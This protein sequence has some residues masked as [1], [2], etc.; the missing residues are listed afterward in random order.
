MYGPKGVGA[1]YIRKRSGISIKPQM[2]GGGQESGIRPGTLPTHQLVGMGE[3]ARL[4]KQR[5]HK[6][7]ETVAALDRYLLDSLEDIELAT[8]NGNQ[9]HRVP[10]IVN[11]S[12]AYVENESL[13]MS[14]K[15]V[16]ISSGSACTSSRIEPSHVLQGLGIS[17][18]MANCSVRFSLGRQTTREE[19]DFVAMRVRKFIKLL[20]ELSPEWQSPN[21]GKQLQNNNKAKS[22][23]TGTRE[24]VV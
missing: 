15:D 7:A 23:I 9:T 21:S 4:I 17:E 24:N 6:D 20:R 10:G 2:H 12:F 5:L 11:I 22:N 19:I 8:L 1:L 14:L 3:A 16:A 18:D 13:M